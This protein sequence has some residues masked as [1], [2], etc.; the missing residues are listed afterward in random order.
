MRAASLLCCTASA[1]APTDDTLGSWFWTLMA[2]STALLM[3]E[4]QQGVDIPRLAAGSCSKSTRMAFSLYCTGLP[5][6]M[7]RDRRH[8]FEMPV[9]IFTAAHTTAEGTATRRAVD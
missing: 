4:E 8:C 2:I 9:G 5:G 3:R 7:V 6:L 1:A